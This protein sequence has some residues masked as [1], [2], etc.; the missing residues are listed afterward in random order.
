[1]R[2][3][4]DSFNMTNLERIQRGI[5]LEGQNPRARDRITI[6]STRDK[7]ERQSTHLGKYRGDRPRKGARK[8]AGGV[9]SLS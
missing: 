5:C 1:V 2:E 6:I 7:G 9:S 3:V 8:T 4:G